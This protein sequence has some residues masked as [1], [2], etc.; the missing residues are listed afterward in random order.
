MSSRH[1]ITLL[2]CAILYYERMYIKSAGIGSFIA[3]GL[4]SVMYCVSHSMSYFSVIFFDQKTFVVASNLLVY[5]V[6]NYSNDVA[7]KCIVLQVLLVHSFVYSF[8]F[9][10]IKDIRQFNKPWCIRIV[11]F[12]NLHLKRDYEA[13][14][15]IPVKVFLNNCII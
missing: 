1:N 10:R 7:L 13:K 14:V 8:Y 9:C 5:N 11:W 2:E 12:Q 4:C 6:L 3:A 15:T